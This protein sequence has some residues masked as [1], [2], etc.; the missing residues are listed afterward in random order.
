M[1]R[2]AGGKASYVV[3]GSKETGAFVRDVVG[4]FASEVKC[5]Y[6]VKKW[7]P[8]HCHRV[9]QMWKNEFML[10]IWEQIDGQ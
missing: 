3:A 9:G 8:T 4:L 10:W 7:S 2:S 5:R 6:A 1:T